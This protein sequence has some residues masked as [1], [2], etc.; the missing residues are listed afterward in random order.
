LNADFKKVE[1]QIDFEQN[2]KKLIDEAVFLAAQI[3]VKEIKSGLDTSTGPKGPIKKVKAKT[4][5]QKRKKGFPIKP[6][7]RT[8]MMRRLPPVKGKSGKSTISLAKKRVDVAQYHE[9]GAG[10]LPKREFFDI[11]PSAERKIERML[12][13]RLVKLF[14]KL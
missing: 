11:Y 2:I 8:G 3:N 10:N 5:R 6:L 7:V 13:K 9:K 14:K 4:A 1:S 12:K